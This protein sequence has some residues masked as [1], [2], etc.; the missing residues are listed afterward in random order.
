YIL[1]LGSFSDELNAKGLVENIEQV[2]FEAFLEPLFSEHG[3]VWRVRLGPYSSRDQANQ[4]AENLRERIG[5]DGLIM[6]YE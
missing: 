3:T 2:G 6:R 1:Q 5:R 4:A